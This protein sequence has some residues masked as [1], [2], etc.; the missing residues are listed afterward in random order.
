MRVALLRKG[1]CGSRSSSLC[2]QPRR[3]P[4]VFRINNSCLPSACEYILFLIFNQSGRSSRYMPV[5]RFATIPSRSQ[6]QISLKNSLP[7][8]STCCAYSSRGQRL[9]RMS[10]QSRVLRSTSGLRRRSTP[11][12]QSRSKAYRMACLERRPLNSQLNWLTPLASR[13][14][15]KPAIRGHFKT[16]HSRSGTLDVVPVAAF[17]GKSHF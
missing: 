12:T 11:F 4:P 5:F 1:E 3:L 2:H 10:S 14:S 15:A 13:V 6:R 16:V 7:A 8:T 17:S 9:L